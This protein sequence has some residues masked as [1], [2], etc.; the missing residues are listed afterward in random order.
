[1]NIEFTATLKTSSHIIPHRLRKQSYLNLFN[2]LDMA[3]RLGLAR[4]SGSL[5]SSKDGFRSSHDSKFTPLNSGPT[6]RF[7]RSPSSQDSFA[8]TPRQYS[9]RMLLGV[10]IVNQLL[11]C[12]NRFTLDFQPVLDALEF[13]EFQALIIHKVRLWTDPGQAQNLIVST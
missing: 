11:L 10:F 9:T 13:L 12:Y 5:G 4:G 7:L 2:I 6:S 8:T 3:S 1:M